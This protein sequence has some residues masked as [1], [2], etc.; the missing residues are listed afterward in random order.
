MTDRV[1]ISREEYDNLLTKISL[2]ESQLRF[3]GQHKTLALGMAGEQ[4]V[5]RLSGGI[6]TGHTSRHDI[7][8]QQGQT[9]EVKTA[10]ISVPVAAKPNSGKRWQWHKI[11]GQDGGKIYDWLVLIGHADPRYK[12]LYIDQNSEYVIFFIPF[13]ELPNYITSG[14]MIV[15]SSNPITA[16][17]KSAGMFS[18]H[19][20]LA[21]DLLGMIGPAN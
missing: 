17:G 11:Y 5:A 20:V 19:Q 4:L 2:L 10:K 3:L 9:I 1:T 16:S 12:E 13:G 21:D 8:L 14:N 6:T 7:E 18:K 15:L